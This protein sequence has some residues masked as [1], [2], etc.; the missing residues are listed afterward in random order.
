MSLNK[1]PFPLSIDAAGWHFYL[2]STTAFLLGFSFPTSNFLMNLSLG[3]VVICLLWKPDFGYLLPLL[4]HPLVWLPAVMFM[5]LALSLLTQHHD[6]GA[7][8]V[9][10]YKK[11]LFVLPLA[12]F[13]L[14]QPHLVS[15]V[16]SG[17]LLANAVILL[18]SFCVGISHI[19]LLGIDPENP[20]VFK[21]HITQNVFMAF[22]AL[23]WLA[24]TF[25]A[26]GWQRWGYC[27]L[28]ILAVANILLMVQ[29]RTGYIALFVGVGSWLL[30]ALSCRM[31]MVAVAGG[32]LVLLVM[33]L[34]P[35]RASDRFALGIQEIKQCLQAPTER[36]HQACD[37][38]M[39]Q[40]LSFARESFRLIKQAP[41]LG[42]G[43]GSFWY[44]NQTTGYSINNP[45][46][47]YLLQTV[48]SGLL[49]LVLFL[50]WMLCCFRAGWRQA[51]TCRNLLIAVL[52]SYMACHLFNSF[53]LDSSEGHLFVVIAAML[54]AA[55]LK[56]KQAQNSGD[57]KM[58]QQR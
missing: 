33:I 47:E 29:G 53:L 34:V 56:Q 6:Y 39:G 22:A 30:L 45:H 43:A 37:N 58:E 31:R 32:I 9:S 18:L 10:K 52:T 13:F 57:S 2:L 35:N 51:Q 21:L 14:K 11:L 20:T 4:R 5:L 19:S 23:F 44:G 3:M 48:H 50:G 38:S 15:R 7:K 41:L 26:V 40:R 36:Q 1:I 28:V 24:R 8:M 42:N 46:N 12:L 27:L 54:A 25:S 16:I 55:S 17:F 49:G